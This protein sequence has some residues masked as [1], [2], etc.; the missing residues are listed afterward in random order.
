MI[1]YIRKSKYKHKI[2]FEN[3]HKSEFGHDIRDWC[4][5]MFGPGGRKQQWRFG[6]TQTHDTYYFR[7]EKDVLMFT[8]RW[9]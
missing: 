7:C 5:Q 6:W 2:V 4:Y 9:S 3:G 1:T 8:L